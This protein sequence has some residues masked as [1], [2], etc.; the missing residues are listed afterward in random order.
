MKRY[1]WN[2]LIAIDQLMNTLLGGFPDETMSSR[3]GKNIARKE[4]SNIICKLICRFL[5]IFEKD[6]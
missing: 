6:H 3:M 5:D 2:L 4:D 1:I